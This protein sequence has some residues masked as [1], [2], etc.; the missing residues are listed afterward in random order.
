MSDTTPL[1]AQ[2]DFKIPAPAGSQAQPAKTA[3]QATAPAAQ[4]QTTQ[5]T[6]PIVFDGILA[7]PVSSSETIIGG[8]IFVLLLLPFF[9]A[10]LSV[11]RGLQSRS[12]APGA[13]SEAGWMMFVWLAFTALALIAAYI[14]DFWARTIIIGPAAAVSVILLVLFVRKRSLALKTRR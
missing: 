11:T 1:V 2:T 4:S 12:A 5:T 8:V 6:V 9:F 7:K 13:A 10:K 14:G 3:P